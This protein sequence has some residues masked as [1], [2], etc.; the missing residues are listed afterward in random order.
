MKDFVR[1]QKSRLSDI[2]ASQR[3]V[4]GLICSCNINIVFDVSCF[5]LDDHDKLSDD[6]YLIFYNQK[7]SPCGS[8]SSIGQGGDY[9]ERFSIDLSKIPP[10]IK[11]LVFVL[12]IDGSATM[13]QISGGRL[14]I[15][16]SDNEVARFQF[17]GADF[18]SEKALIAGELY[19]KD[20]WR[21]AA[22]GQGF[23]GGLSALLTHFGATETTAP[24]QPQTENITRSGSE[25]KRVSLEKKISEKAP[26]L[27]S[28]VKSAR[29]SLQKHN[30]TNHTAKVA[31][32]LDISGSMSAL[33][34]SGKM[35]T[36][37]ERVLALGCNFDDD[38]S[39]DMFLFGAAAHSVG[40][41]GI[42]N[43]NGFISQL[44]KKY[45]L[46]GSTY[47]GKVMR[48][49]RDF[50]FP[51]GKSEKRSSPVIA[52]M[53]VY[54]MFVTDGATFDKDVTENQLRWSSY[55]PIFWQFMAIGK[56]KKD[57][58]KKGIKGWFQ[59]TSG[60]DFAFLE[61]LDTLGGRYVD[62]ANFFSVED[63]Q[64]ISDN[65]LYDLLMTEYPAWLKLARE[66]KLLF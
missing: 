10:F 66:K 49:I 16:D 46:E 11:K 5:G 18:A 24:P 30:L 12:T 8:I 64:H 41:F 59:N 25:S 31:L 34:N 20:V 43:F 2:T 19:L 50:Y 39:I 1:G 13:S 61:N 37:A 9:I 40:E 36:L 62:N 57:A 42:E 28:L 45:P 38:G 32:C 23:N 3:V 15:L 54:V 53:P 29:V 48:V 60:S 63:P 4:V 52:K 33:Y 14:S 58:T 44:I 6:R 35:Q 17:S 7:A 55:E 27:V 65:E 22:V 47:Y 56:S 51:D 21:F 26:Q